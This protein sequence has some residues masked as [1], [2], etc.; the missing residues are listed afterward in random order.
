MNT[1]VIS[2]VTYEASHYEAVCRL[3]GQLT[4]RKIGFTDDAYRRLIASPNSRLF[5]LQHGYEVAGMLTLGMYLSPTGS[6]AW[7]EDVVVD[8]ACRGC[9]L[10]RVLVAHAM[11]YCEAE[12]ID[13][14]YLTSN[15]RR[16]AANALYQSMSFERKET[17]MYKLELK[18]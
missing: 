8:E 16:V 13:T 9:G 7:I 10:G 14:V 11:D 1:T 18:K 15:P 17:N 4:T 6:K 12:G 2:P 5:L 3:L